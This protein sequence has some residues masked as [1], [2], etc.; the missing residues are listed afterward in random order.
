MDWRR[1][2]SRQ[3]PKGERFGSNKELSEEWFAVAVP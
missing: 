1:D 2:L 3:V